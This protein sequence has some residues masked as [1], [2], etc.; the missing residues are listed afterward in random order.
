MLP[1]KENIEW[2]EGKYERKKCELERTEGEIKKT[3]EGILRAY[4]SSTFDF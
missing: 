4:Y 2:K 3:R 1:S